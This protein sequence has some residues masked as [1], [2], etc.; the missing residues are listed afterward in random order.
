MSILRKTALAVATAAVFTSAS[1][2][3]YEKGDMM[4]R[5]GAA[6][7]YPT[8]ES[9]SLDAVPGGKVEADS[10]WSLG[11]TF[12]YMLTDQLGLGVLG[13]WPFE[14][15]I[16]GQGTI[17]DLGDVGETKHLPPTVTLQW[18][19]P[20]GSSFHPYVGA[21]FNYTYFFDEDTKGDLGDTG[22]DLDIDDSWGFAGEVGLDYELQN[23]WL[24][25][26]QIWYIGIEPEAKITG[27]TLGLDE[28][29]DVEI[30]PW[31]FLLS[32]GKKF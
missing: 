1:A 7:V 14:H 19:F 26:G 9:D 8:G 18:H 3:A 22:A 10:A 20:T 12:T 6:G 15:D 24:L 32:A 31:V 29:I 16:E 21:G 30:D 17:S 23:E 28:K 11:I 4:L 25:S 27:G 2:L 5:L 13:A